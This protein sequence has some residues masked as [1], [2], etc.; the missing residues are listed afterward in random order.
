M[1]AYWFLTRWYWLTSIIVFVVAFTIP[2]TVPPDSR[3][4]AWGVLIF[5]TLPITVILV[6][7]TRQRAKE[8][9]PDPA[10][11]LTFS[12]KRVTGFSNSSRLS[13]FLMVKNSLIVE[14]TKDTIFIRPRAAGRGDIYKEFHRVKITEVTLAQKQG[15]RLRLTWSGETT[16]DFTLILKDPDAFLNAIHR[17]SLGTPLAY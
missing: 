1:K 6:W 14:V 9:T 13:S 8:F 11:T 12:E 15:N 7:G 3:L 5:L 16:G 10:D 2:S 17:T 4:I